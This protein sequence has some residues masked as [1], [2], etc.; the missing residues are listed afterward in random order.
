MFEVLKAKLKS[1]LNRTDILNLSEFTYEVAAK[2]LTPLVEALEASEP[3]LDVGAYWRETFIERFVGPI[4]EEETKKAQALQCR[5]LLIAE[6]SEHSKLSFLQGV[7]EQLRPL[8]AQAFFEEVFND[9]YEENFDAISILVAKM[10]VWSSINV[11]ALQVLYGSVFDYT[12]RLDLF[13]DELK[14]IQK[15]DVELRYRIIAANVL[16]LNNADE[17]S[18]SE[19]VEELVLPAW[20]ELQ[21]V[22]NE[23]E[24]NLLKLSPEKSSEAFE[25]WRLNYLQKF[26]DWGNV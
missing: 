1:R 18:S 26:Q 17:A 24:K 13:I 4:A 22:Q 16:E 21:N 5:R 25:S 14:S 20:N 11:T 3:G 7:D 8:L 23:Y 15:L 9:D 10:F 12:I 19:M 6:L 2:T